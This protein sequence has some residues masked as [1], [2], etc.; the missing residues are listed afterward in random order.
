[1]PRKRRTRQHVISELGANHF[2]RQAL[3]CGYSVERIEHDYGIDLVMFTYDAS[4]EIENGQ[5]FIQLKATDNLNILADQRTI[6]FSLRRSDLELWLYEPM[7]CM[8]VVF[9]AAAKVAYW[10][11]L[12]A[13]FE[14]QPDFDLALSGDTIT[15]HLRRDSVV[16]QAA[17]RRF[18]SY[19]DDVLRQLDGVIRHNV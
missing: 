14:S 11:Y 8:L 15:V 17:V 6:A 4:G 10:T 3:L 12:Q 9:D 13:Y 1:M 19:R 5:V 18:A 2:E 16:D 7:P